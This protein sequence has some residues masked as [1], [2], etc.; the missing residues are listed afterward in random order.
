[1]KQLA[2][3]GILFALAAPL[4]F[5]QKAARAQ[6]E[7]QDQE[8]NRVYQKLKKELAP[9]TFALVREDQRGWVGY[10]DYISEWQKGYEDMSDEEAQLEMAA[11]LTESRIEWLQAWQTAGQHEG[12]EGEY[13][14]SYG[15][16]LQIVKEKGV[17]YFALHV[18]RGP[19]FH[20]GYLHGKLRVNGSTAWFEVQDEGEEKPTW[21]TLVPTADDSGRIRV[22]TENARHYHGA[23]AYFDNSYLRTG[24]V[25]AK[26]RPQV[27]SGEL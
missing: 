9:E 22:V 23:R 14:D 11:A 25:S 6:F 4:L 13:E 26:D 5:G 16:L 27:I 1:M 12:L 19:T 21:M 18:V 2:F 15:G 17:Y 24:R 8:L 3:A 20:V 7:K 10:R